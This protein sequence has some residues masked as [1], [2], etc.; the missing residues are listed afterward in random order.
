[1]GHHGAPN[2]APENTINSF[3]AAVAVGANSIEPD[4]CITKDGFIVAIHDCDPDSSI[5]L[6][7][8]SGGEGFA[9]VP[10]VPAVGSPWR[11]PVNQLTLTELRS[12]YGYR[13]AEGTRD[14]DA[15]IPTLSE[16]L[17]W[18][19]RETRLRALY[20]DLKF[21]P[22][23]VDAALR[24]MRELWQAWQTDPSLQNLQFYLLNVHGEVID[25]LKAER[26]ALALGADP[27]RIVLDLEKPGA[28]S[29]TTAAGLRD[30]S[31]GLTPAF[32]W[33]GY[34]RE[35]AHIVE[36]REDGTIDSVLAWTFDREMQ[37]AELL[38]YSVDGIITN[39]PS[40]LHR[41]WKQT[42]E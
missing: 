5:A 21:A 6:A 28:L 31:V 26:A 4:F 35:I 7:R 20:F 34:K 15:Q 36:A 42:L 3:D 16:V 29:A 12:Y 10:Y 11:R 37:L 30:V 1:V 33:S 14:Y 25:A 8:Q 22:G 27:L 23:E 32:T 19:S 24:L 41:M 40:T 9:W 2:L 38:Y 17:T 18:C 39:D 13:L